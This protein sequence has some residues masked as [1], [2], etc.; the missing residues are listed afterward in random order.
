MWALAARLAALPVL[1]VTLGSA[2]TAAD[3]DKLNDL[4]AR[5]D[6]EP[7]AVRKAKMLVSLGDAQFEEAGRAQQASD[8]STLGLVMEK[9]RDNVRA[10]TQALRKEQPDGERHPGG[11]KQLEMHVQKGLREIGEFILEVPEPYKP[12][13]ELVQHDLLALD[14]QLIRSLFPRRPSH[15]PQPPHPP[16]D[17]EKKP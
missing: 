16:T 14:D 6:K 10:A 11:Y 15:P 17:P 12:P 8:F 3:K 4:Q 2:M 9:Y 7:S 5:F 1:A 13:L